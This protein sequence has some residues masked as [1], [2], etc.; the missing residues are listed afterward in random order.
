MQ[1]NTSTARRIQAVPL[2]NFRKCS[3]ICAPTGFKISKNRAFEPR[4]NIQCHGLRVNNQVSHRRHF[5]LAGCFKWH[6]VFQTPLLNFFAIF[7]SI[8]AEFHRCFLS[9]GYYRAPY[10]HSSF[11]QIYNNSHDITCSLARTRWTLWRCSCSHW[12]TCVSPYSIYIWR[13]L[14]K[15]IHPCTWPVIPWFILW[16]PCKPH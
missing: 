11:N 10:L 16:R 4:K 9:T 8:A 2:N 13:T 1:L 12:P 15:Y 6:L 3:N 7:S 5:I 14:Y